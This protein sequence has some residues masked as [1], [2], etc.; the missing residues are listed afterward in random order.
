MSDT[1][2][3]GI[4]HGCHIAKEG[5]HREELFIGG[6]HYVTILFLIK[7]MCIESYQIIF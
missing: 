7:I 3:D 2:Q 4:K 6:L 5:R 1:I